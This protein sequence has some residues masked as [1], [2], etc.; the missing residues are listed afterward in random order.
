MQGIDFNKDEKAILVRKLQGYFSDELQ[1]K[2][3]QFD[4]EFLLDFIGREIGAYY[5]N[6]GLYDAQAALNA[7]MEDL[8]DTIY[9]LEQRTDLRR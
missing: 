7:R 8:Q 1:Q 3:G 2:I 6:R 5:Y 9:Q 4:A